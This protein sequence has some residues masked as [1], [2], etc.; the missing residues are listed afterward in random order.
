MSSVKMEGDGQTEGEEELILVVS[1]CCSIPVSRDPA[2][3]R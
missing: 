1:Y 3:A 2:A